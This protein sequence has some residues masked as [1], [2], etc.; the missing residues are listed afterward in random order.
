MS[1]PELMR[2]MLSR[3]AHIGPFGQSTIITEHVNGVC[4][5]CEGRPVYR[6]TLDGVQPTVSFH[7]F[8]ECRRSSKAKVASL[9][10]KA[11]TSQ[12]EGT[13]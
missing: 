13:S 11:T 9:I 12:G 10:A 1:A 7:W 8:I 5:Q 2:S 4:I 6:N 3:A